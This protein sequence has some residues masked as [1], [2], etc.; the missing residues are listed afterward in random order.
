MPEPVV[1]LVV[2]CYNYARFLPG[3]FASLAAQSVGPGAMELVFV[4]DASDDGSLEAARTLGRDVPF[5][6]TRFLAT[7][8]LRRP[9]PVRSLGFDAASAERIGYVD[10]DD[11]LEPRFLESCLD[12]IDAG[13]DLAYT[14]NVRQTPE[15]EDVLV[16]PAV[17]AETLRTQNIVTSPC[18]MRREVWRALDGFR[19]ETT[20]ED[21]DFWV[22]AAAAG[23]AF[24][25]V[26]EPLHRHRGHDANYSITAEADDGRAKALIV[27]ENGRFFAPE[28]RHW[29]RAL[30]RGEAWAG[31]LTRGLIPRAE[32]VRGM[33]GR[34]GA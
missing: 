5:A 7:E 33:R 21:W 1:S 23:F 29:A 11:L 14:G 25:R 13:A 12:A 2:T 22:Q 30:L 4:D 10:A 8:G 28:V 3:L 18:V 17:D 26:P 19:A 34:P 24:A 6:A 27:T 16:L 20:Y 9:G 31:P 32:D 15:G